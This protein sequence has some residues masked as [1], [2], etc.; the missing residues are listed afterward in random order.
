MLFGKHK[1]EMAAEVMCLRDI[2][3]AAKLRASEGNESDIT[4]DSPV[5][6]LFGNLVEQL[7]TAIGRLN[8]SR[9]LPTYLR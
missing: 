2:V 7:D 5:P 8:N 9:H 4:V 3:V 1:V 6:Y